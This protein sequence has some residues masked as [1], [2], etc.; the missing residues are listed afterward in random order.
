MLALEE[1]GFLKKA[2]KA[3]GATAESAGLASATQGGRPMA[4]NDIVRLRIILKYGNQPQHPL[5]AGMVTAV[6]DDRRRGAGKR[7]WAAA[8]LG[9]GLAAAA[10]AGTA[11]AE[12]RPPL[13]LEL[14]RLEPMAGAAEG[15]RIWLV[16][17]NDA[18]GAPPVTALRLDLVMFGTDGQIAR[19][20]AVELG[21][22]G[23]GRTVVRLF[24]LAGLACDRLGRMLVNDV[25]TCKVGGQD[26][27]DCADRLRPA[28]RAG[29]R[30]GL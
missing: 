5:E 12:A 2:D 29:I 4:G 23:A 7:P 10:F 19:R 17:A 9:A 27:P 21:P 16:L 14:N 3:A 13:Q 24:D 28:S 1:T 25:L 20:A 18:E 8:L 22:V 6:R 15:C 30:F 26:Q 11:Q